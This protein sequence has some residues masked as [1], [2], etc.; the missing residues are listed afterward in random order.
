MDVAGAGRTQSRQCQGACWQRSV[1]C[2]RRYAEDTARSGRQACGWPS[3]PERPSRAVLGGRTMSHRQAIVASLHHDIPHYCDGLRVPM[4][5]GRKESG[6]HYTGEGASLTRICRR[7]GQDRAQG[8][9]LTQQPAGRRDCGSG[10]TRDISLTDRH[11]PCE[12]EPGSCRSHGDR[13]SGSR[14]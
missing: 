2:L 4:W 7:Y 13:R 11:R 6:R 3:G 9:I 12:S 1:L 8:R 5:S 14:P 10:H